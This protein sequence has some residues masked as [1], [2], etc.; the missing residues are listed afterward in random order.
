MNNDSAFLD[1]NVIICER[2]A[3]LFSLPRK[4][5]LQKFCDQ[6]SYWIRGNDIYYHES[7]FKFMGELFNV[8]NPKVYMNLMNMILCLAIAKIWISLY[9]DL[10]GKRYIIFVQRWCQRGGEARS[11]TR[12]GDPGGLITRRAVTMFAS[13]IWL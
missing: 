9:W 4:Q 3:V 7:N 11:L 10:K 6:E 13:S 5:I 12:L 1:N 8:K 2:Y